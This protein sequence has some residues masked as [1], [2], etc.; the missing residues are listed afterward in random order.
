MIMG[1]SNSMLWLAALF[2]LALSLP[3]ANAEIRDVTIL[4]PPTDEFVHFT[5]GYLIA[6]GF[7]DLTSLKFTAVSESIGFVDD[8]QGSG[9]SG[10]V[11]EDDK[12]PDDIGDDEF[13]E[14]PRQRQRRQR[15]RQLS[16]N[17]Q[18]QLD[19]GIEEGSSVVDIAVF[20]LP[21]SCANTRSGC[22]W[23]DLGIGGKLAD[24]T[25]RWCCSNDAIDQGLCGGTE[26]D[27]GRLIINTDKFDGNHRFVEISQ[28]G[29][30]S[31]AI[32]YGK[33]EMHTTGQYVVLFANCNPRDGREVV[34]SGTTVWKSKDGF[35]PG[36]LFEFM[37]FY[38]AMT[39]IYFVLLLWYGI[40]MR[41]NEESRIPIEKWFL[42]TIVLGLVEMFFRTSDYMI[43]NEDGYRQDLAMYMGIFMGAVKRGISRC[44]GVMVAL[45]WGV[46]TDSLG[47]NLRTIVVLGSIYIGVSG[48]QS[49][50][51]IFAVEDMKTL[52]FEEE[53]E[54][55]DV[56]TVL[57]FVTAALDVIF[58]MW[59]LDA[60]NGTMES[61]ENMGQ[62][63]KL[64]R[65]LRLRCI[66]LFAILFAVVWAIFSLVDTYDEQGIVREEQE[67]VIDA[68]TE[69]NYLFVLIAVA[70]LWRPN[71]NAKEYAYVME[72]PALG[73]DDEN[74][75][76]LTC[77]IPSAMDDDDDQ[78]PSSGAK[79]FHDDDDL[80]DNRFQIDD[81]EAT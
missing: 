63:R 18:R 54:L 57:T 16:T 61:L 3:G 5:D 21:D 9:E 56:V 50:M 24:K 47:S 43:W 28:T 37:Y 20:A 30:V 74:D 73:G 38:L 76:E 17:R 67:W 15:Q 69:I 80:H 11:T 33:M 1:T 31:K 10:G 36:E 7:I 2:S 26:E 64:M 39:I 6:P 32:R 81:A 13:E 66:F 22:D 23:T 71:P 29:S 78:E 19:G 42:M 75:L 48:A 77:N 45:G 8:D 68:T 40:S 70:I 72:L 52:S 41:L 35:L 44:L 12:I 27:Y 14:P 34:V 46:V 65:Y 60:L 51:L 4:M 62:S 53:E 58:I 55:F 49:L 25:S 59:I 79:G